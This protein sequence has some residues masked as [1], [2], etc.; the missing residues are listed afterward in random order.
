GPA[1]GG[2]RGRWSCRPHPATDPLPPRRRYRIIT[3]RGGGAVLAGGMTQAPVLVARDEFL[4]LADRRIADAAAGRG[5][6]LLTAGEAGIGKTRLLGSF[7]GKAQ[8]AGFTV[9]RAA[10][11]PGDVQ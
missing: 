5:Q 4:I 2:A 7:A 9:I 8:A 1:W 3:F 6:L 10:A 11:Y